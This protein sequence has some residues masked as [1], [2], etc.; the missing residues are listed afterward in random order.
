[1]E[2]QR[3]TVPDEDNV[4]VVSLRDYVEAIFEEQ[5][6]G[7][8]VAEDEREKAAKALRDELARAIEEGDR[9]LREH[10]SQQVAQ[11]REALES[12]NK[13]EVARIE[14]VRRETSLILESN[15]EA[16]TKAEVAT[17]KRF[18]S[19]NEW[20]D[21]SADRERSQQEDRAALESKFAPREV[22][23]AQLEGLR[24]EL[25]ELREKLSKLV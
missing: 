13:L 15:K 2:P 20:R 24:R 22:V 3:P 12:A 1:M 17:E 4:A 16:V 18:E 23:D 21:Q 10:I 19:V 7:M 14:G 8:L 25:Q 11:I 9:A 6:R 5:R